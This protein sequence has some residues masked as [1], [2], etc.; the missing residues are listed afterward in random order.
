MNR[1]DATLEELLALLPD[2]DDLEV[3]RLRLVGAA[4]RDPGKEWDSSSAYATIDKRIVTPEAA[5]RAITE[6]EEAL[7]QYMAALHDGLRPVLRSFFDGD[8]A[9]TA[10]HLIAVGEQLEQ[11]GRLQGARKCYRVAL[12]TSLPLPDKAPQILALRRIGRVSLTL[13]DFEESVS[14][15]ER[16]ARLAR[17]AGDLLG[18]VIALT[19]LGNVRMWQGRW[20][21]AEAPYH[22][23]L[24]L[25]DS[26]PG[27]PLLLERGQIYNNLAS[28]TTRTGRLDEAEVWFASAFR[29]WESVS[30][31]YDLAVC[32]FNHAHL[33]ELQGRW[34]EARDSY[35]AALAL[36]IPSSLRTVIAT[37]F[38]EWWLREGHVTQ[39]EEWGRVS[40]EH[41]ISAR[42]PYTLGH[43]YRARGNIARAR[44]DA[45]GITFYEKAL[46][47]AREKDYLYLEAE[48]LVDY[49]PLRAQISGV[50]EAV[51]Y[52]ERARDLFR[53]LG[54]LGELEKAERVLAELSGAVPLPFAEP[55]LDGEAEP[56]PP[57]AAA[58]D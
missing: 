44:G 54:A 14:Y 35:E 41:A 26:S 36:P 28:A 32:H 23:A 19:G 51:A 34:E 27:E 24:A 7:R 47:I 13:G 8:T 29:H 1:S 56:E 57:L 16:S 6:A 40:E 55:A 30:S 2:L 21:E 31:A 4:V 58:G 25:A 9:A 18:Q 3:L 48:T 38:A 39:A 50:E 52:V 22:E 37:D 45:D 12:D 42:S 49:A 15:Y 20:G 46:E 53:E 5:E 43:M 11:G 10:R 33:R 17:D